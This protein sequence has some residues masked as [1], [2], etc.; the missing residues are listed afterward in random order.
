[1][2]EETPAEKAE[3]RAIRRR[4]ITI[5]EAVAVAGVIIAGLTFWNG[6]EDRRDAVAEREVA[7]L[8]AAAEK[9]AARHRVTLAASAV[10]G[11]GIAFGAQGGCPLQSSEI[12]FPSAFGVDPKSTVIT[13][14]IESDWIAKP[15][16]KLTDGGADRREG[17]VPVLID[18]ECIAEDGNRDET[19]I[20]DL[21]WQTEPG[22]LLGGRSLKLRGLVR[23]SPG[24]D[25]RRLDALWAVEAKRLA[26]AVNR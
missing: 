5:G 3:T 6:Y 16:L 20:Y 24:G 26:A 10:D 25:Q 11:D 9:N 12:R 23:R 19:A 14:R 15:L 21:L 4:W 7:T 18:A 13:H 2:N 22:G 17:R 8:A 1:M